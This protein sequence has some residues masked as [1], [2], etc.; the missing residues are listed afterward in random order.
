MKTPPKL[1]HFFF[2]ICA[3]LVCSLSLKAEPE[4]KDSCSKMTETIQGRDTFIVVKT[5]DDTMVYED[6]DDRILRHRKSDDILI[7]GFRCQSA[8]VSESVAVINAIH[9]VAPVP[10]V[11]KNHE[12]F[13]PTAGY[14]AQLNVFPNPVRRSS[15][16]QVQSTGEPS[17]QLYLTDMSGRTIQLQKN[18]DAYKADVVPGIYFISDGHAQMKRIFVTE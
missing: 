9:M 10:L 8:R 15:E 17:D 12:R 11:E 13:N 14:S 1:R 2:L 6:Y 3:V 4:G 7:S 18:A 5:S 16:F